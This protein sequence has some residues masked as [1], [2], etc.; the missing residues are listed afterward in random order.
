VLI[1]GATS[2]LDVLDNGRSAFRKWHEMMKLEEPALRA[3]SPR[4][5]E[6]ALPIVACPD[7]S[8]YR[9]RDVP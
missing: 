9:C 1:V 8:S 4:T 5:H 7:R 3:S 2:Q 6:R